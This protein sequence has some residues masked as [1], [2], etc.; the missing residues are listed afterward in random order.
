M[1]TK[2][3]FLHIGT[4]KTGT[5]ALQAWL[6]DNERQLQDRG[7]LYP[8]AGRPVACGGQHNIAWELNGDPRFNPVHGT[9]EKLT[10]EMR[11]SSS[12][13][14]VLSSED[15]EYLYTCHDALERIKAT[16]EAAGFQIEILICFREQKEYAGSLYREL[17]KHGLSTSYRSFL[18][19]IFKSGRYTMNG[20]WRFCFAY[21]EL[22]QTF[23]KVFGRSQLHVMTYSSS[24]MLE[25]FLACCGLSDLAA[26]LP[27]ISRQNESL[28]VIK[29]LALYRTNLILSR[30]SISEPD[31]VKARNAIIAASLVW[32]DSKPPPLECRQPPRRHQKERLR[33]VFPCGF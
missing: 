26:E 20:I 8:K 32:G 10:I 33:V 31:R 11:N 18:R 13:F 23:E 1:T 4:H 27:P 28:S 24:H 7:V 2:K 30:K 14:V 5:T 22:V 21:E 16:I 25:N 9:L 3:C 6:S 29:T 12:Q 15:F 17:L 19:D